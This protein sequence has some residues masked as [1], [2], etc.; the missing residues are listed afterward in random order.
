MQMHRRNFM[1]TAAAVWA[2]SAAALGTT[3]GY[4]HQPIKLIVPYPPGGGTDAFARVVA[5]AMSDIL[6]QQI[7]VDNRPGASS[8][9]GATL[10]ARAPADGYTFLQGDMGT[11]ATNRS[12]FKK[13]SY[14]SFKDLA[15]ITLTARFGLMLVVHP[16]VQATTLQEF[17]QLAKTTPEALSYGTP[18]T[19]TPHHLAMEMLMRRAGFRLTHIPYRGGGPAMQDLVGGQVRVLMSDLA[20]ASQ[21]IQTNKVRPLAS[22]GS[23]R[24]EQ[25]RQVPTIAESG[26]DG[27]DAWAWQGFSA[28]AATPG[29]IIQTLNAAY[30]KAAAVPAVKQRLADLGGELTPSSP[31]AMSAYMRR[32][33]EHWAHIIRDAHITLD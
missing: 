23:T 16:S 28:P 19:G 32:E 15:P 14:D 9:I 11:Y 6:G 12:M 29:T 1:T 8:I 3:Q 22:T 10:A 25:A 13:I 33:A 21:F 27:F 26:I 5:P 7:V 17:I 18:G 4:P 30:A 24:L 2:T 20:S 31:Q